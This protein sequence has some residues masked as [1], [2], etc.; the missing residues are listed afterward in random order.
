MTQDVLK[1]TLFPFSLSGKARIWYRCFGAGH[2]SWESLRAAFCI[3]FFPLRRIIALRM[4]IL[5]FKQGD[6]ESLG[7][8]WHRFASLV[9]T[10]PALGLPDPVLL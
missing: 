1:R 8:T 6:E 3:R 7:M 2:S 5:S 4:V 9:E 10:C